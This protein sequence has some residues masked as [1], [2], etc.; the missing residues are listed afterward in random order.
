MLLEFGNTNTG[1]GCFVKPLFGN[2]FYFSV[3]KP[4]ITL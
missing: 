1:A 3:C 4:K 2:A